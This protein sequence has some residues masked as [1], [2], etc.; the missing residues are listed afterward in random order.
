MSFICAIIGLPNRI[1]LA[2]LGVTMLRTN[3]PAGL[4]RLVSKRIVAVCTIPTAA[5]QEVFSAVLA[6]V[7]Q[8]VLKRS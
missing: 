7:R 4:V 3:V 6:E 8:I 2:F 5:N 1:V